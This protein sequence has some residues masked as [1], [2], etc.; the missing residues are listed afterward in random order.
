MKP[1]LVAVGLAAAVATAGLAA[2]AASAQGRGGPR[3][4]LYELP[5]Y[6]GQARTFTAAVNN[7]AD[8]GF[9]D[10]AQSARVEGRWRICEDARLRGRCVELSGDV[11]NLAAMRMTVAISSFESLGGFVGGRP[12]GGFDGRPGRP[13]GGFGGG[14]GGGDFGG[15]NMAGRTATF[16]PNPQRG[17]YRDANEFCRR[18]GFSGSVYASGRGA[19]INDVL[20]RR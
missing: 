1:T 10:R 16:F 4:T 19:D 8:Q 11:P 9:N 13:G 20:C 5:N 17:P 6:Q 2:G 14:P 18:M 3:I 7:L 12:G 15:P